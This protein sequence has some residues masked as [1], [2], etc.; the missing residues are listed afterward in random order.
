MALRQMLA[1]AAHT[2]SVWIRHARVRIGLDS[3]YV[4]SDEACASAAEVVFLALSSC[5]CLQ[6][7]GQRLFRESVGMDRHS[8]R[9]F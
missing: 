7:L 5:H 2:V 9:F 4:P 6:G 1:E 8:L 3:A